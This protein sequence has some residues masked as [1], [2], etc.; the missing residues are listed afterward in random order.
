MRLAVSACLLGACCRYDG[1][2][3]ADPAVLALAERFELVPLCPEQLGGLPTPRPAA[4]RRGD[5][6]V[7]AAG[8]DVT[9]E[10]RRGAEEALRLCRLLGIGTAVLKERSPSCGSGIIHDGTFSGGLTAGDGVAAALL[11][12]AGIRV[13]GE[14]E[15]EKLRAE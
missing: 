12:D 4:E 14:S 5:A 15:T 2:S 10:Y 1:Q 11:R 13:L 7:T 3:R 8:A 9:A 6:V